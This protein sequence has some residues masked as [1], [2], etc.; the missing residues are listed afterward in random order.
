MSSGRPS[1]CPLASSFLKAGAAL[2]LL[3]A[4]VVDVYNVF[5]SHPPHSVPEPSLSLP[6]HLTFKILEHFPLTFRNKLENS[7]FQD[8]LKI[9][10][11]LVFLTLPYELLIEVSIEGIVFSVDSAG[12]H[13]RLFVLPLL[14][15]LLLNHTPSPY[16]FAYF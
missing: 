4:N 7:Y 14:R 11:A 5:A 6:P 13:P 8:E 10:L 9:D 3:L 15:I 12:I 2:L 1:V 16:Y